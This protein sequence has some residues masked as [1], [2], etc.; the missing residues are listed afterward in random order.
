MKILIF[1]LFLGVLN[2]VGLFIDTPI[3]Y[4]FVMGILT[5][6]AAIVVVKNS[7]ILKKLRKKKN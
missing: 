5:V 3:W 2:S 4:T 1:L 7:H 6:I